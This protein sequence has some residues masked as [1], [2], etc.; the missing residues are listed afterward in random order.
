MT[1]RA[2]YTEDRLARTAAASTSLV[3]MLR[4]LDAPLGSGP[5][6][7]LRSRLDHYGIATGHFVEEPLP[8]RVRRS[9]SKEL[10]EEA[11]AR[12]HSIREMLDHMGVPPYD[13]AYNHLSRKL[14]R[15]GIDTSHFTGRRG[16]RGPALIPEGELRKAVAGSYSLAGVMRGLGRPNGGAG[17]ALAKRSIAAYGISTSH[18]VGQGHQRGRPSPRR[19]NAS[20]VLRRLPTGSPRA[21]TVHLR[22]SLDE[23]GV[24]HICARCG[25]GDTW[26]GKRLVLEIDHINGD[27]L[28]NRRENLRYLCPNCHSVTSTWC[29]GGR[30][31]IS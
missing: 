5:R 8:P 1:R 28:D 15:Y 7:Y 26:Q 12:C 24:P 9:Y 22:R 25:T 3:D 16:N 14:E 4:R 21:K 11:A 20:Q 27:R 17:R 13:S 19:K 6:R 31:R 18:F 23:L 29:R 2:W 30:R 10:L